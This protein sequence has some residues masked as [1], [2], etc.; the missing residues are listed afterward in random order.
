M[1]VSFEK[2]SENARLWIYQSDRKLTPAEIELLNREL[3]DFIAKW[4]AHGADLQASHTIMH[5]QFVVIAVD[6]AANMATGCS[7]DSS[8]HKMQELSKKLGV[9]FFDRTKIAFI[10]NDEI[11]L[12]S[13]SNLKSKVDEGII[14]EDTPVFNN[15]VKNKKEL[16]TSWVVPAKQSWMSRYFN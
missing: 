15:L 16:E 2:I 9:D 13:L 3:S 4:A 1:Q 6:E 12:E 7:I 10:L 8:V 5:S 14:K 11:F